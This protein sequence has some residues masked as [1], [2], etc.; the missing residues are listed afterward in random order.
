M[1]LHSRKRLTRHASAM[2]ARY[3]YGQ[4]RI[5]WT[6]I[7]RGSR[8]SAKDCDFFYVEPSSAWTTLASVPA[9]CAAGTA[10]AIVQGHMGLGALSWFVLSMILF[11][12]CAS[13]GQASEQRMQDSNAARLLATLKHQEC[14]GHEIPFVLYLRPFYTAGQLHFSNPDGST[15]PLGYKSVA[16]Q[17]RIDVEQQLEKVF[18]RVMPFVAVGGGGR[19]FGAGKVPSSDEEWQST[20]RLLTRSAT[21]IFVVPLAGEGTLWEVKWLRE[22]RL[23]QRTVFVMPAANEKRAQSEWTSASSILFGMGLSLPL[24][25]TSGSLFTFDDEGKVLR[26]SSL[27]ML[28]NSANDVL[29]SLLP[30]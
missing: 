30:R 9:W 2:T 29:K 19:S 24:Y 17:K 18:K 10:L 3:R 21:A 12:V 23:I 8:R 4:L 26:R 27:A 20:V 16:E 14:R 5:L 7:V 22:S 13:L 11:A 15:I 28:K 1:S 25:D 6:L